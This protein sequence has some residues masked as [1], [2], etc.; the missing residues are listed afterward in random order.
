[1]ERTF[2]WLENYRRLWKKCEQTLENSRKSCLLAVVAI[3][4]KRF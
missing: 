2:A 1:M 4:L 3:L